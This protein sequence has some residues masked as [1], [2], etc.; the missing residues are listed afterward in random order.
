MV[1]ALEAAGRTL[2][3]NY[4]VRVR[5]VTDERAKTL[6][7]PRTALFRGREGDWEAFQVDGDG[8]ARRISLVC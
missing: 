4:R 1:A 6:V 7:V 3:L 8:R 2:G 5:I